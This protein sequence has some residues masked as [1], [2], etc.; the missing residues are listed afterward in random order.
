MRLLVAIS[1]P[2]EKRQSEN[3][4]TEEN[5]VERRARLLVKF[6]ERSYSAL[7]F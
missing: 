6:A 3:S 1:P 2:C 7:D 5:R 4:H